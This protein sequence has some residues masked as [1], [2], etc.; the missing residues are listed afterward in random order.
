MWV[1]NEAEQRVYDTCGSG[2]ATSIQKY[3]NIICSAEKKNLTYSTHLCIYLNAVHK[4]R[5]MVQRQR[6]LG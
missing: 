4:G 3:M 2:S 6:N 1:H 5:T